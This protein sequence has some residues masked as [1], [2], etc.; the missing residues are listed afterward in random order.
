MESGFFFPL[1]GVLLSLLWVYFSFRYYLYYR[2]LIYSRESNQEKSGRLMGRAQLSLLVSD[3]VF[4]AMLVTLFGLSGTAISPPATATPAPGEGADQLLPT[5]S[6]VTE[7][8]LTPS[9][10]STPTPEAAPSSGFARIGNT[11]TFG[12]YVRS[13]PGLKFEIV[14]QLSDG[15]RVELMGEAQLA[16]G[17]N[18]QQVRLE[19]GRVGWVADNFLI[20]E[21]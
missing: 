9:P 14:T 2:G 3:L 11:N 13:E 19:D 6:P 21:P 17:F 8:V 10:V 20:P 12:V 5:P 1:I 7:L 15:N 4:I 16:D 18:W